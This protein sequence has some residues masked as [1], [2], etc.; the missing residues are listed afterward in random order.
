M[1]IFEKLGF[2]NKRKV[3]TEQISNGSQKQ[4]VESDYYLIPINFH[5]GEKV[6]TKAKV[7]S[8]EAG[9][10]PNEQVTLAALYKDPVNYDCSKITIAGTPKKLTVEEYQDVATTYKEVGED[11]NFV[12]SVV[13]W[14]R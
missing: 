9:K 6:T 10:Y 8:T 12:I 13:L 5:K 11:L 2:G 1:G 7:I 3:N 4:A 14:F